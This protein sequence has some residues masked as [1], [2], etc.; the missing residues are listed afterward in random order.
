MLPAI[1][2]TS[3]VSKSINE[4]PPVQRERSSARASHDAQDSDYSKRPP[5]KWTREEKFAHLEK[6][7]Q[8]EEELLALQRKKPKVA[9]A[10]SPPWAKTRSGQRP[11][12]SMEQKATRY[13]NEASEGTPDPISSAATHFDSSLRR[14]RRKC[15]LAL[16]MTGDNPASHEDSERFDELV[17]GLFW[18]RLVLQAPVEHGAAAYP[19]GV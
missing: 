13:Y 6:Q 17:Q 11:P 12:T 8:K 18:N 3:A 16:R 10:V 1:D 19:D 5:W 15:E 4:E 14:E 7:Q 9:R 2:S